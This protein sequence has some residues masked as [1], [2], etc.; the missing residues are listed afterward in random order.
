MST[1]SSCLN[2]DQLG[3]VVE[4][5][6]SDF[7]FTQSFERTMIWSLPSAI[8]ILVATLRFIYVLKRPRIVSALYLQ[9]AKVVSA[10][11]F[12]L[13]REMLK[14]QEKKGREELINR[15]A[16]DGDYSVYR[17]TNCTRSSVY[18]LNP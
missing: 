8:F 16:P 5:C 10:A 13:N 15:F 4:G 6:R 1:N 7:D 12:I 14:G 3:P 11:F 9:I 18:T 17:T 2:D